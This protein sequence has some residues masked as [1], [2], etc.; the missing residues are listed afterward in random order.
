MTDL[1]H[2]L[3]VEEGEKWEK[4]WI[5]QHLVNLADVVHALVEEESFVVVAEDGVSVGGR[6]EDDNG[7]NELE[8]VE[9]GEVVGGVLG[10]FVVP[11]LTLGAECPY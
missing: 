11:L 4:T 6:E 1:M 5:R 3:D 2:A 7:I 8:A 10:T 9:Q